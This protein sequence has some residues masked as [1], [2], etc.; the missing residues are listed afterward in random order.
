M[1]GVTEEP[2]VRLM[3]P[4]YIGQDYLLENYRFLQAVSEDRHA[5]PDFA[6]AVY[7]H[8]IVDAIYESARSG[9]PI[10]VE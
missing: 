7:A 1:S 8:R 6:V 4:E 9:Q 5:A 3:T 10:N 2:L